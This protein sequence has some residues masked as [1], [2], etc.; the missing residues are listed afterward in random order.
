M[1]VLFVSAEVTPFAR[2]GGLGDVVGVLPPVLAA[3][4]HDVRVVM[5]LYQSIR[6]SDFGLTAVVERLPVP[7][8]FGERTAQVWQGTLPGGTPETAVPTYFIE[9]DEYFARPGLY[10]DESGEYADNG[11]R[12]LFFCRAVLALA[13]RLGWFPEVIH[14]HDWHAGFI[15]AYLRFLPGLNDQLA[16]AASVFTIHN[17][18]FQGVFP[19][20]VFAATGLPAQLFQPVGVE[21]YGA[22]NFMKAGLYYADVLSTVSPT[23]AQ[24]ICSPE[25]GWGL[26]GV[27]RD[28]RD[29]LVGIL[30]GI[31]DAA[32]NPRTDPTLIAGYDADNLGGKAACRT[33]LLRA[34]GLLE[35]SERLVCGMVTRLTDQKGADLVA[36][37]IERAETRNVHFVILGSGERGYEARFS[38]L[39][40]RYPHRVGVRLGFNDALSH[41]IQAGSDC[42]LVPS[43]FEPC[44][45]TQMYAMRYGTLPIVR[46]TGG[47]RDTVVSHDTADGS[48]T[49]FVFSQATTEA[50]VAT[51]REA[52]TVFADEPQ[53]RQLQRNAM[54]RD[55]SWGQSAAQ[56]VEL[57]KQAIAAK[58]R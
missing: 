6:R 37:A 5:P 56:Y 43:R 50:L 32:W 23:Y 4:G 47:L 52:A 24:E 58:L 34:F 12:F 15:P 25:S 38:A 10:G 13:E 33:T 11:L 44:G 20:T 29:A 18:A 7:L 16:R 26:D 22:V 3:A 45:L 2:T 31:D 51:I 46:A 48:G 36:E 49:G 42:L 54:T 39:A 40:R 17:L 21:F 28:R 14:C 55:F 9:Q 1:R 57:Y 30:N 8:A 53:W 27:L 35:D 41:Q 19:G